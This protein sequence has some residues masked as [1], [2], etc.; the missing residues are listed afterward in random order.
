[1]FVCLLFFF[2]FF[3][4]FKFSSSK[5]HRVYVV[6]NSRQPLGVIS[7]GDLINTLFG[8]AVE[9]LEKSQSD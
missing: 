9:E 4:V 3:Q 5:K 7:L 6:D 8:G 2:V 1:M